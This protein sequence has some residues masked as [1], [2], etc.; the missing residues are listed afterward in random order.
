MNNGNNV[1]YNQVQGY[2]ESTTH[3]IL[4]QRDGP[5]HYATYKQTVFYAQTTS[6]SEAGQG[7]KSRLRA[8]LSWVQRPRQGK[9]RETELMGKAQLVFLHA[10]PPTRPATSQ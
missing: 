10:P 7:T 8:S 6:L 4:D 3:L 1:I 2:Q 9:T 5:A